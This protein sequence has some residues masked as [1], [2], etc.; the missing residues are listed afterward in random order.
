M[1]SSLW[2]VTFGTCSSTARVLTFPQFPWHAPTLYTVGDRN[3]LFNTYINQFDILC[4]KLR[5]DRVVGIDYK[6]LQDFVTAGMMCPGFGQRQ[7]AQIQ[8][9]AQAMGVTQMIC[10][11]AMNWPF[12]MIAWERGLDNEYLNVSLVS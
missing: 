12:D 2:K 3:A 11:P 10:L 5:E 8:L 1:I 4:W 9:L 7:K 6:L